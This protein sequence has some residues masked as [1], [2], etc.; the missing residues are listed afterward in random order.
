MNYENRIFLESV[1]ARAIYDASDDISLF[2]ESKSVTL[3]LLLEALGE[4]DMKELAQQVTDAKKD[5]DDLK[6][7]LGTDLDSMVNTTKVLNKIEK[8]FPSP[9]RIAAL[10]LLGSKKGIAKKVSQAALAIDSLNAVRSSILNAAKLLSTELGTLKFIQYTTKLPDDNNQKTAFNKDRL[11]QFLE[12]YTTEDDMPSYKDITKGIK[13]SYKPTKPAGGWLGKASDL[14][15]IGTPKLSSGAFVK[16]MQTLSFGQIMA[17]GKKAVEAVEAVV[18][19]TTQDREFV[20]SLTNQLAPPSDAETATE[21]T[22]QAEEETTDK[23]PEEETQSNIIQFPKIDK[24]AALGKERFGDN[25]DTLIRN[26]FTDKRVMLA[27]GIS[28]STRLLE[29]LLF[30]AEEDANEANEVE[31]VEFDELLPIA[32]EVGK[33]IEPDVSFDVEELSDYF[34]TAIEQDLLPKDVKRVRK[35]KSGDVYEYTVQSG[36]N[37]NKVRKVKIVSPSERDGYYQAQLQKKDGKF[38]NDEY[39]LP[40]K[41]FGDIVTEAAIDRWKILAGVR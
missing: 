25:G 14:L 13:R 41:G 20:T 19:E 40:L 3:P 21:E 33:D 36:K 30:E 9:A 34:D 32:K 27:F 6:D 12:K 2:L 10:N 37:K 18:D 22:S 11:D 39:S 16:D 1:V 26:F 38:T 7:L 28:E 8:N 17:L 15:G 35:L 29:S 31:E 5:L 4:D 24:L 23:A